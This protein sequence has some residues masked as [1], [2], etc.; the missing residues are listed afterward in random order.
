MLLKDV[1][2][3]H[4]FLECAARKPPLSENFP[5]PEARQRLNMDGC[6]LEFSSNQAGNVVVDTMSSARRESSHWL[7]L[8]MI[9]MQPRDI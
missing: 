7:K 9:G 6:P 4:C 8:P 5:D 2:P 1:F 3:G